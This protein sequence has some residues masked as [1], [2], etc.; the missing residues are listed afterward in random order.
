MKPTHV[1]HFKLKE[2]LF[3]GKPIMGTY[4]L[5]SWIG[6]EPYQAFHVKAIKSQVETINLSTN[7]NKKGSRDPDKR[8][9]NPEKVPSKKYPGKTENKL[10][11]GLFSLEKR[12][13]AA[14]CTF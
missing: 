7:F 13:R 12:L 9:N 4:Q 11:T 6:P 3:Q 5:R 1:Y 8:M 2:G 14:V 10:V